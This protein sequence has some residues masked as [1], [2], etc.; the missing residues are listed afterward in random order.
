MKHSQADGEF[1]PVCPNNERKRFIIK[2]IFFAVVCCAN[3]M[4]ERHTAA[5][6][7]QLVRIVMIQE[8]I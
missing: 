6:G 1:V 8:I 7:E 2:N 5:L 3:L 4:T